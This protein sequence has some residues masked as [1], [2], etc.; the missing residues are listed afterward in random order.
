M[1]SRRIPSRHSRVER[2][3]SPAA[4]GAVGA[5]GAL[6]LISLAIALFG[7]R[8]LRREVIQPVQTALTD[9]AEKLW[10]EAR[11]LRA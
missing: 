3:L 5:I 8:R 6:G 11:R 7:P 1:A 2:L 9:R 10:T 4:L